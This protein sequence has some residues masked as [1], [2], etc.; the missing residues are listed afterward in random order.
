MSDGHI[1]GVI[2]DASNEKIINN[3]NV[4]SN[5]NS[6]AIAMPSP[7]G[8]YFACGD[9]GLHKITISANNYT[10]KQLQVDIKEGS[11]KRRDIYLFP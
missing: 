7:G 11:F 3:A 2:Y 6:L 8:I 9:A 1:F 5:N 10:G 4:I